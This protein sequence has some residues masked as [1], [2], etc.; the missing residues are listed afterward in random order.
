MERF[1]RKEVIKCPACGYQINK[2]DYNLSNEITKLLKDRNK[3]TVMFLNK[4]SSIITTNIPS[5]SRNNYHK[6]LVGIQ[7][8][9]DNV[10]NWAIEQY[11]QKKYYI[12]GKGFAYLRTIVQ[13]RNKNIG[14]LKKNERLLLGSPPP[15]IETEE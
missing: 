6:F 11:F 1:K 14:V 8:A 10:I 3:K 2:Y 4:I 13:N 7:E 12:S 9:D 5:E 15:V